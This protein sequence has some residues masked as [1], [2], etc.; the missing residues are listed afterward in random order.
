MT[1][2][3]GIRPREDLDRGTP[4]GGEGWFE[5]WCGDAPAERL[6]AVR[7]LS[8]GFALVYLLIRIPS[9][10]A[11]ARLE[12]SRFVPAGP[13]A[14]LSHPLSRSSLLILLA[15]TVVALAGATLG[16]RWRLSGPV[17]AV[18]V[19]WL[20]SY[21]LSWGQVLHTENLLVLHL[22][23][24]AASPAADA[25]ALDSRHRPAARANARGWVYGWVLQLMG[26]VTVLGY[27]VAGYAK[28]RNGGLDW[29]SGDVLRSHIALDNL[30]KALYEEP[31][32]PLGGWL[33]RYGFLFAPMAWGAMVLELGG[34]LALWRGPLRR[35]WVWAMWSFHLAVLALMAI[36]FPYQLSGIAF[37]S[38]SRP[39]KLLASGHRALAQA[40]GRPDA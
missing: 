35:L 34:V 38:F 12:S 29:L 33:T 8:F 14:V 4:A 21:R 37:A 26:L 25:L 24:L 2:V 18:G 5:R 19:L 23:I 36:V 9:V 17:A 32:S 30:R 40:T 39:E 3:V 6:A 22:L 15:V 28:L 1:R 31:Y 27:V 20:L 11:V 13:V 7:I 10:L 16:F